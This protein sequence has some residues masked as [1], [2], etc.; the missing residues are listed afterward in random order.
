[1]SLLPEMVREAKQQQQK[2]QKKMQ[3][4]PASKG[5]KM[6]SKSNNGVTSKNNGKIINKNM[7]FAKSLREV[8]ALRL[9]QRDHLMKARSQSRFWYYLSY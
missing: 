3:R 9:R 1:M 7:L 8:E 4:R 5:S 6:T 2:Q